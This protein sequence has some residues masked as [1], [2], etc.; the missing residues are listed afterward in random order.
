MG[1]LLFLPTKISQIY[2]LKNNGI[3]PKVCYCLNLESEAYVTISFC[4]IILKDGW[5]QNLMHH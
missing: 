4:Q 2:V 3:F 5:E 1:A